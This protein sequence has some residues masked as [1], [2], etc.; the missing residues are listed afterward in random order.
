[1]QPWLS[2]NSRRS[3]FASL[4]LGLSIGEH[5]RREKGRFASLPRGVGGGHFSPG[6]DPELTCST[7]GLRHSLCRCA[8]TY[9]LGPL[10][11]IPDPVSG[12]PKT[13]AE[14]PGSTSHFPCSCYLNLPIPGQPSPDLPVACT[15]K[16]VPQQPLSLGFL[17]GGWGWISNAGDTSARDSSHSPLPAAESSRLPSG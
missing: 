10:S 6:G 7:S 17:R 12:T 11:R 13:F 9:T 16:A 8:H 14:L 1:M 5:T 15:P 4:A 2:G 3:A